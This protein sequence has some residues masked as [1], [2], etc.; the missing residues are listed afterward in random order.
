[1][2]VRKVSNRGGNIIGHFPSLKMKRMVAFESTIERDYLFLLDYEPTV[3]AFEEQPL[4]IEYQ[5]DQQVFH[6]TPDFHVQWG[7]EP[8]LVECKTRVLVSAPENLHK[9]DAARVFC[10]EHGY[11]FLIMTDHEIRS[12]FRLQNVKLLTQ[13]AR[14]SVRPELRAQV[15]RILLSAAHGG[16]LSL[17]YLTESLSPL[18][19][20]LALTSVLSLAFHHDIEMA[21]DETALSGTSAVWLPQNGKA[22]VRL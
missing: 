15:F 4:T 13:F 16:P 11:A 14:H 19:P 3:T 21:L 5:H 17:A 18:N 1:M 7:G 10:E 2:A 20:S 8:A 9:F 6:Y 12:G 22:S